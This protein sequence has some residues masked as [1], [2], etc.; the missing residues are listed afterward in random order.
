MRHLRL[1]PIEGEESGERPASD[2]PFEDWG[3]RDP[4]LRPHD[5]ERWAI[6]VDGEVVGDMSAHGRAYGPTRGS[7]AMSIGI[8]VMPGQRGRGIGS[9]AQRAL[10]TLLHDRGIVRV[11]ASTDVANVAEQRALA[12][13]GF[14]LEGVLRGAQVRADGRHDLQLWSH[15]AG[16]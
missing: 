9:A 4:A 8:S 12:R 5:L 16:D 15:L 10:A 11:E 3:E 6:E 2:S 7:V 13:A 1:V 14:S